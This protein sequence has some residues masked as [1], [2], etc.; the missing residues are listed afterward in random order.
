[1]SSSCPFVCLSVTLVD[2]D[3]ISWNSLKIISQLISVGFLLSVD[4]TSWIYFKGNRTPPNFCRNRSGVGIMVDFLPLSRRTICLKQCKIWSKF[5]LITK[6]T[7]RAFDWY[8]NRWPWMTM[9]GNNLVCYIMRLP[10]GAHNWN[11]NEDGG[12]IGI[13]NEDRPILQRQKCNTETV[14]CGDLKGYADIRGGSLDR[15]VIYAMLW[16]T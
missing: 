3:H 15:G 12:Q 1:M 16:Q 2:C 14:L 8:Q 4:P 13:M 11:L 7:T 10:F 6:I 9:K 5:L